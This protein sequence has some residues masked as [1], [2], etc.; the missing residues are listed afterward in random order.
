MSHCQFGE[1][2]KFPFIKYNTKLSDAF[3]VYYIYQNK[4]FFVSLFSVL[5]LLN[6]LK[7]NIDLI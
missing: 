4:N 5:I 2:S 1:Y 6:K 7:K 3:R